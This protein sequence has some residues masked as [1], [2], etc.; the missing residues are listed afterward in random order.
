MRN[1]PKRRVGQGK[2][3]ERRATEYFA[4]GKYQAALGIYESKGAIIK[5][6]ASK[7]RR[8]PPSWQASFSLF[9]RNG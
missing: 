5:V 7:A 6:R 8:V 2:A 1:A 3:D 9:V 4:E